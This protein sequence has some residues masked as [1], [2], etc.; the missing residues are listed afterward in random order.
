MVKGQRQRK[1]LEISQKENASVIGNNDSNVYRIL[2]KMMESGTKLNNI[3][4]M[5]KEKN[6]SPTLLYPEKV[7]FRNKAEINTF[8]D[9][10]KL[11]EVI[12]TELL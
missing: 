12:A 1:I 7:S 3:F 5:L 10:G 2:I 6:G 8:S 4:K 9:E 11:K